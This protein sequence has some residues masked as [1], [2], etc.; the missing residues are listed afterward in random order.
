MLEIPKIIQ[1]FWIQHVPACPMRVAGPWVKKN[2]KKIEIK[3]TK[4]KSKV[5]AAKK[6]PQIIDPKNLRRKKPSKGKVTFKRKYRK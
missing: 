2:P 3:K 6:R 5:Q 1:G 4:T